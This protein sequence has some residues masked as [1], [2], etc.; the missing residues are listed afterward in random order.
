MKAIIGRKIGMSQTFSETG[1][2]IGVT[3]IFCQD[4]RVT[5]VRNSKRDGYAAVQL[6][7]T[8]KIEKGEQ[9]PT[10]RKVDNRN[11]AMAREF[12]VVVDENVK[13]DV[14]QFTPGDVVE[15]VGVS[16]GKGFQGV[17]KRHGFAGGPASHGHRHVLR[18]A[19]SIGCRFP[20]HVRKGQRMAGRMGGDRVTVKNL[21]VVWVDKDQNLLALSGAVPGTRGSIVEI[22]SVE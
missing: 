3:L 1:E 4:N 19:G 20:Q 9:K 18:A 15:V 14:N 10:E 13:F 7:L 11:I 12:A 6:A 16:K 8:K 17:V 21:K 2:R 22:R 5:L